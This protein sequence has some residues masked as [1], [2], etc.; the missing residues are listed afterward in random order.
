VRQKGAVSL[1][2]DHEGE[3]FP[4]DNVDPPRGHGG[5]VVRP[6][7]IAVL[8]P[9]RVIAENNAEPPLKRSWVSG[10]NAFLPL[11]RQVGVQTTGHCHHV[12]AV[13]P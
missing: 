7:H 1:I 8:V 10:L 5:Q 6:P 3:A 4:S 9:R 12:D 13:A 2:E 11:G